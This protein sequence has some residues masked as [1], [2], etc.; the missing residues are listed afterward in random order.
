MK[1]KFGL[2]TIKIVNEVEDILSGRDNLEAIGVAGFKKMNFS[3]NSHDLTQPEK[4]AKFWKNIL[5]FTN[6]KKGITNFGRY[7]TE[8][9]IKKEIRNLLKDNKA[10][11]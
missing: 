1:G 7:V 10:K 2:I 11:R 8:Q 6:D 3:K 9:K 5:D 4:P